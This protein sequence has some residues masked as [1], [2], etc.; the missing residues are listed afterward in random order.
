MSQ[1]AFT[2]NDGNKI[3]F[4]A[5]GTGTSFSGQDVTEP[6]RLAIEKG[7]THLDGA[8]VCPRYRKSVGFDVKGWNS[9]LPERGHARC[10]DQGIGKAQRL[11]F[12]YNQ[13]QFI[14]GARRN[15]F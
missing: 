5:F 6:V 9:V 15:C 4:L 12:H 3:P 1:L 10:R 2:L 11:V 7:L 13:A 14:L 8:Q